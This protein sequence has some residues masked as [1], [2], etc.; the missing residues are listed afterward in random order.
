VNE[1]V[2]DIATLLERIE[3]SAVEV[4][5]VTLEWVKVSPPPRNLDGQEPI[6]PSPFPGIAA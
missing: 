5:Y 1:G 4:L 3:V 2:N 6:M